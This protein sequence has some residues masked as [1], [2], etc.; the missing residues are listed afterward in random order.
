M[1]NTKA[2]LSA[3]CGWYGEISQDCQ[4]LLCKL[5]A[6]LLPVVMMCSLEVS[7][8]L[9]NGRWYGLRVIQVVS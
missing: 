5:Q 6:V 1:L 2:I 7:K 3:V 9:P 8:C 4:L